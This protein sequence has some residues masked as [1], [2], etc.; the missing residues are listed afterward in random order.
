MHAAAAAIEK[1][2]D[3]QKISSEESKDIKNRIQFFETISS[4]NVSDSD[5]VIEV[6]FILIYGGFRRFKTQRFY[7]FKIKSAL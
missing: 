1:E 3:K 5:Y 2:K 4:E 6:F 7:F